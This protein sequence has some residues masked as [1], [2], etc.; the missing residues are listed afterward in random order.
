MKLTNHDLSQYNFLVTGGAGFIGSN[1]SVYLINNGAKS[2]RV[3]DDLSTGFLENIKE[4]E[5]N[6]KFE[7]QKGDIRNYE[8]CMKACR[9]IDIILHQAALGSVPRSMNDPISSNAVNVNGFVNILTAAKENNITRFIYASS[10]SVYGD[11]PNMP[12]TEDKTGNLLS[13]YAVTKYTNELYAKVFSKV[14]G[15]KTVGMRYFNVFGPKQNIQGPYAAVIPIFITK[16]LNN[17]SPGIYGDGNNTRDFTFI[18]NVIKANLCAVFA[19]IKEESLV[20]NVA[21]GG[22]TS[23]NQLFTEIAAILKR[24]IKATHLPVRKGDIKDSFANIDKAKSLIGY[25][26]EVDL[27]TGLQITVDWY[28]K[29]L[30]KE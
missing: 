18:A 9:G 20:L 14:Y 1:L 8:D 24:D 23:V 28:K 6:S 21:Y 29:N 26:S 15:L 19:D 22:T 17:E 5:G 27:K 10:S 3:L 4:L 30:G 11:D 25:T 7:F 2:V 12:K 16:L 13:P